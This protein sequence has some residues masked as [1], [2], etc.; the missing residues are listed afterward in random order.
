M[1]AGG[2]ATKYGGNGKDSQRQAKNGSRAE[3]VGY[4]ATGGD[5]YCEGDKICADANVQVNGFNAKGF[6][7]I[8]QGGGYHRPI[9]ELHKERTGHQ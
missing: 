6:R 3:A 5:Q 1:G 4:P 7:H 2:Q 9:K 8:W